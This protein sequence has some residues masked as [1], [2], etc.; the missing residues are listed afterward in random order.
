[1]CVSDL[2]DLLTGLIL[3]AFTAAGL[4]QTDVTHGMNLPPHDLPQ[5][6][7]MVASACKGCN[8]CDC[9]S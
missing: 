5:A 1:M 7:V 4:L 9:A 3:M 2:Q 6:N 8:F